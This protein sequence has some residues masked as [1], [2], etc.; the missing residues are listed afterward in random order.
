MEKNKFACDK[1]G[2]LMI[3]EFGTVIPAFSSLGLVKSV[4]PKIIEKQLG[5]YKADR[6][7]RLCAECYLEALGIAP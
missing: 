1:C 4:N 3:D 6:E 2:K 7:Y 5:Q